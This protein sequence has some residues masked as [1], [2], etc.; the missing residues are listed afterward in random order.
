MASS[1]TDNIILN[2]VNKKTDQSLSDFQTGIDATAHAILDTKQL[3]SHTRATIVDTF[4]SLQGSDGGII[5]VLEVHE[6]P[7]S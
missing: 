4:G 1:P 5:P 6:L 3:I 2:P 7:N